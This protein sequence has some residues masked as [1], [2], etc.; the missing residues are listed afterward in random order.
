ML[1]K[2]MNHHCICYYNIMYLIHKIR[3][4]PTFEQEIYFKKACGIARF[5]WNYFLN[6]WILSHQKNTPKEEQK[7]LF[8]IVKELNASKREQFPWMYDVTKCA[9]ETA[10]WDLRQ[11][12]QNHFKSPKKF[13]FPKFKKKSIL[14]KVLKSAMS[15]FRLMDII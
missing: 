2:D 9:V 14:N 15:I 8:Q 5:S 6:K 11:A 13:G 10:L 7:S 3:L 12:F 1:I 4:N